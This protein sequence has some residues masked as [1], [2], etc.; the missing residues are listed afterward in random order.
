MQRP[1]PKE[2]HKLRGVVI[3]AN[4]AFALL[5]IGLLAWRYGAI[6]ANTGKMLGTQSALWADAISQRYAR[7]ATVCDAMRDKLDASPGLW[8]EPSGLD[9][10]MAG[11]LRQVPSVSN[12]KLVTAGGNIVASMPA[13]ASGTRFVHAQDGAG[14]LPAG[15]QIGRPRPASGGGLVTPVRCTVPGPSAGKQGIL[16]FGLRTQ[17]ILQ[18]IGRR[19]D[20]ANG[21]R[22]SPAVGLIRSDG[23]L[24][25]RLPAFGSRATNDEFT[26]PSRG[27]LATTLAA[28][29]AH[30]HGIVFGWVP[31][32]DAHDIIAWQRLPG[33]NVTAFVSLPRSVVLKSWATQAAPTLIGWLILLAVQAVGWPWI[34]RLYQ[35]QNRMMRFN[36]A[37][38]AM[39][40]LAV[41]AGSADALLRD[42][43]RIATEQ[44]GA[45]LA[46]IG[47]PDAQGRLTFDAAHGLVDYLAD[48]DLCIH[49][50]QPQ[51]RGPAGLAWRSGRAYFAQSYTDP[52]AAPW[53]E[54]AAQY[55]FGA[56]TVLPISTAGKV[57]ALFCAYHPTGNTL[58]SDLRWLLEQLVLEIGRGLDRLALQAA[59]RVERE[60]RE[61]QQEILRAILAEIETLIGARNDTDL[62]VSA[63]TR[64]LESGL[65][66]AA[67]VG[68]PNE[69]GH[70]Q[71]LAAAGNGAEILAEFPQLTL[72][73]AP[74]L[75]Q[76]LQTDALRLDTCALSPLLTPWQPYALSDWTQA[77]AVLTIHRHGVPWSLLV[78]VAQNRDDLDDA[79]L[80]MLRWVPELLSRA[81]AE[82]DLKANLQSEQ[83]LQ[84]HL[85]WHD[86][87]TRL[88]NRV[89]LE[90]HLPLAMAR[91]RRHGT[92]LAVGVID[93][94]DFKRVN[95]Q[96]GHPAGD[97]LLQQLGQR[98][99]AAVRDSDMV[100]RR[101]GDEFVVV[102]EGLQRECDLPI[103]LE[104]LHSAVEVPF[105]LEGDTL[106]QVGMSLGLTL[107]P[108]DE[109]EPDLLL[110]HADAA[111]YSSKAHKA[112][113]PAWWLRWSEGWG[114][115]STTAAA[116]HP[117]P[118]YG[119]EVSRLLALLQDAVG[120]TAEQFIEHFYGK[121][122]YPS[123]SAR[124]VQ[125]LS[126]DELTRL[127]RRQTTHLR[128]IMAP[129]L[130]EIKHRQAASRVGFWHALAGVPIGS[131]A[132]SLG[133]Y[134]QQLQ[135][136]MAKHPVPVRDG[137]QLAQAISARLQVEIEAQ[138]QSAHDL[139]EQYQL[140]LTSLEHMLRDATQWPDV[141]RAA[142]NTVVQLPG[143]KGTALYKANSDG[144]L[145]PEF[146]A[147]RFDAY[148]QEL[149]ARDIAPLDLDERNSLGN[150]PQPRC[151]RSERIETNP[152]FITDVRMAPWREAAVAA[153]IRSSAAV[154]VKDARGRMLGVFG[155]YGGTPGMFEPPDMRRFM[156]SLELLFERA[157]RC[158]QTGSGRVPGVEDRRPWR[159]RLFNG[160][161]DMFVQPIVDLRTGLPGKV[162][163]LARLRLE[164]GRVITPDQFL[165]WFGTAE[166]VRLFTLGLEQTL[167]HVKDWGR[168]GLR[169]DASINLPPE[170][171]LHP[172]CVQWV[173]EG[174]E[175]FDI[176]PNRLHLEILEDAEFQDGERRDA[177]VH[178]LA[179]L[180]VRLV[181]D[182]LGSGYS[183]LL[184]LRTLPFHVVKIDQGLMREAGRDPV[185]VVRFIGSLVRMAQSLGLC[186]VVE[187]LETPEL[188]EVA[189]AL[190]AQFGQ[191]YA[192]AKP[193]PAED[194][195]DWVS[196]FIPRFHAAF[197][198]LRPC[199]PL[200]CLA[201]QW[202]LDG[203]GEP[204]APLPRIVAPQS[205]VRYHHKQS[206]QHAHR[207]PPPA[208][209]AARSAWSR[210]D[211][212]LPSASKE[213]DSSIEQG[214]ALAEEFPERI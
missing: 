96:W 166:L 35:R 142:L 63:C 210:D 127:K 123:Q 135:K 192:F 129:G 75:Q 150:G 181:M 47:S 15:L 21:D 154:P 203:S 130:R 18:S 31:S 161:L 25:A 165:P 81:L 164:D 3:A 4:A 185:R 79:M 168:Q 61:R 131:V 148:V 74:A 120:Q 170:V 62:M 55:G 204:L 52:I 53:R 214:I 115:D 94:D 138:T 108:I 29:H 187:G 11:F 12:I 58:D 89:A 149:M 101:G 68:S 206:L 30:G 6:E 114:E 27:V 17:D 112:D 78:L 76:A 171:L 111:L 45:R 116:P 156:Q 1:G 121:L 175:Q 126:E 106:A 38:A 80:G 172:D 23:Y 188:V 19:E 95:D 57:A 201:R 59:E 43:C 56:L 213:A 117:L 98:L 50:E 54:R 196:Q 137:Q 133:W 102:L 178:A 174:L 205:T 34:T 182:D 173:R 93:I 159:A 152:S 14:A 92:V 42:A 207:L 162:E 71:V 180:G 200:G 51:G 33:H 197:D 46:W 70:I 209:L 122:A 99:K 211:D 139:R 143:M 208:K 26:L 160:G 32:A 151:W 100:A 91:T 141:M 212:R 190:G 104:R 103:L 73:S 86:A 88:P 191:G 155:L 125:S 118:P 110:R 202:A 90:A 113:R 144:R 167:N 65:F 82:F 169:V 83:L 40:Q 72:Q 136:Q 39:S 194:F 184:R 67:W 177:A 66:A 176:E 97:D 109:S 64:L 146:S 145:M 199:T 16:E 124:I 198:V 28:H 157:S 107:Y 132:S 77:A 189:A 134:L 158:L 179:A 85:A 44:T 41:R 128:C 48:L 69:Q 195:P 8:G 153:G 105:A 140:A 22:P 60:S 24:L 186:V 9:P 119:D 163:T 37:L 7:I 2:L 20:A 87:L 5:L 10:L 193:M 147:G 36:A 84:A 13:R 183:S 49:A